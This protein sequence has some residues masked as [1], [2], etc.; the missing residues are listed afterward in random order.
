MHH[1]LIALFLFS[2]LIIGL[3]EAKPKPTERVVYQVQKGLANKEYADAFL[4][5]TRSKNLFVQ[6]QDLFS[7]NYLLCQTLKKAN[8]QKSNF[9]YQKIYIEAIEGLCNDFLTNSESSSKYDQKELWKSVEELSDYYRSRKID[10]IEKL[11]NRVNEATVQ[12]STTNYAISKHYYNYLISKREY[13]IGGMLM[14]NLASQM[15]REQA[16]DSCIATTSYLGAI[17]FLANTQSFEQDE[18]YATITLEALN[19]AKE[20]YT[21][22]PVLCHS[23]D[24]IHLLGEYACYDYIIGKKRE[25]ILLQA[26]EKEQIL[27][28][29]GDKGI[30]YAWAL[31]H[32]GA[33]HRIEGE[34][35]KKKACWVEAYNISSKLIPNKSD[36]YKFTVIEN[37]YNECWDFFQE[38]PKQ[39]RKPLHYYE[40]Q[41]QMIPI[42]AIG[43][44]EKSNKLLEILQDLE[45]SSP[46]PTKSYLDCIQA[47]HQRS[48][49]N[50][51]KMEEFVA[52]PNDLAYALKKMKE[53]SLPSHSKFTSAL[54]EKN[55][56][57]NRI[58]I[59]KAITTLEQNN[60]ITP[61]INNK[62]LLLLAETYLKEQK[63]EYAELLLKEVV[64]SYPTKHILKIE[65]LNTKAKL[66][67]CYAKLNKTNLCKKSLKLLQDE[68]GQLSKESH[69]S[70]SYISILNCMADISLHL[71][72]NKAMIKYSDKVI[73]K[74]KYQLTDL[75]YLYESI[76]RKA[77]FFYEKEEYAHC[78]K[79]LAQI[80]ES[81]SLMEN[82]NAYY[83][84]LIHSLCHTND[85]RAYP[86][87]KEYMS[88]VIEE[89]IP[90][91]FVGKS[92]F[93]RDEFWENQAAQIIELNTEVAH[94]F[95]EHEILIY[96]YNH[97]LFAKSLDIRYEQSIQES[98]HS[99]NPYQKYTYNRMRI[100]Q[101]SLHF[102]NPL[103]S[104]LYKNEIAFTQSELSSFL[105]RNEIK[106]L[107]NEEFF[108]KLKR[109]KNRA[110]VEFVM[111]PD[112]NEFQYFAYITQDER[113]APTLIKVCSNKE[114]SPQITSDKATI[115]RLYGA[116]DWLYNH[117]WA[118]IEEQLND[119]IHEITIL[120]TGLLNRINFNAIPTSYGRLADQYNLT[121][122]SYAISTTNNS[123]HREKCD[124]DVALFGGITYNLST[125]RMVEDSRKSSH[126]T[127]EEQPTFNTDRSQIGFL[128][129]SQLEIDLIYET[130]KTKE[131]RVKK[132]T[133]EWASES[134]FKEF[135]GKSPLIIHLATH[136]FYLESPQQKASYSF[137]NK[138]LN[139]A[140]YKERSLLYSGLL[141]AGAQKAWSGKRLPTGVE[142]GI[143]TADEIARLDLSNTQLV[144]LSACETALGEIHNTEGVLGLQRA[145]KKAGVQMLIMSLWPVGDKQTALLMSHLYR[146]LQIKSDLNS[147]LQ[148][149]MNEVRKVY[150]DPVHWA[151]FIA[152]E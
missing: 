46:F 99:E 54:E 118:K 82:R 97:V 77:R 96:A 142:D 105:S 43:E 114:L 78:V 66:G 44:T 87:L 22:H 130:I 19:R 57:L 80:G 93:L 48:M 89:F 74:S 144:V 16:N 92:Q 55:P 67:K 124:L 85:R 100:A 64:S 18:L 34:E 52:L 51:S 5:L 50:D 76:Y 104:L 150:P 41:I 4:L 37:C 6:A 126:L 2:I 115:Q 65:E 102:G 143:L 1:R 86:V 98:I 146:Y 152:I 39:E 53:A 125:E 69:Q 20:I 83:E 111:I 7:Y 122:A 15:M 139:Y 132:I 12:E 21:N 108:L 129:N 75:P 141:L 36:L 33:I 13:A 42:L 31:Y 30:E 63:W 40:S 27:Q 148:C 17:G 38:Q 134:F 137:Y 3:T 45:T 112:C 73:K 11:W 35:E 147:A 23:A 59:L 61:E 113:S 28:K 140:Y 131:L 120:P 81:A 9:N 26:D 109:K 121:R 72:N 49:V 24:A 14:N 90:S 95:P 58:C 94:T 149:A 110:L 103:N 71:G 32:E 91:Y 56:N 62:L 117:I 116:S 135:S 8:V 68:I 47:I 151:G 88:Q 145:F 70:E 127:Q 106:Q 10:K 29:Y 101:D 136:G 84:L 107:E 138:E 133:R 79:V 60:L 123:S 25:A 128:P 119:S